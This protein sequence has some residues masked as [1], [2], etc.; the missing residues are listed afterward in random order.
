MWYPSLSPSR[1]DGHLLLSCSSSTSSLSP[2]TLTGRPHT[3]LFIKHIQHSPPSPPTPRR[4]ATSKSSSPSP[5]G[6][7]PLFPIFVMAF[8]GLG[9][10]L[11]AS[12]PTNALGHVF[13][14]VDLRS[15]FLALVFVVIV[16][17]LGA[18]PSLRLHHT[19]TNRL[20][21]PKSCPLQLN[22]L[23]IARSLALHLIWRTISISHQSVRDLLSHSSHRTAHQGA[24]QAARG[25]SGRQLCF[26]RFR[27]A[28][29]SFA[30]IPTDRA[31]V[32][33]QF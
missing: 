8:G 4:T 14:K 7:V 11:L 21:Y 5:E 32:G 1:P 33:K 2:G 28:L 31:E 9:A 10:I 19:L 29:H 18:L 30:Q 26:R 12:H 20:L 6:A 3:T 16:L 15:I 25:C 17:V 22:H 24:H 23:H 27:R 13:S